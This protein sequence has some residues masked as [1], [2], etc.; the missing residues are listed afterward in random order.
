MA[1]RVGQCLNA[2]SSAIGGEFWRLLNGDTRSKSLRMSLVNLFNRF[3]VNSYT[4]NGKNQVGPSRLW[5][6]SPL[7]SE[8]FYVRP[9]TSLL[10]P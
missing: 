9:L 10:V 2:G 5:I 6:A 1:I 3:L 7:P 8:I 4:S